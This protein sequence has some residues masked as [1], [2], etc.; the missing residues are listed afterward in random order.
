MFSRSGNIFARHFQS[1]IFLLQIC[2]RLLSLTI[3]VQR[4]EDILNILPQATKQHLS[5]FPLT[6][7]SGKQSVLLSGRLIHVRPKMTLVSHEW[8][9]LISIVIECTLLALV[10]CLFLV[11]RFCVVHQIDV[12]CV[13]QQ[14]D[15]DKQKQIRAWTGA[16]LL[17]LPCSRSVEMKPSA[18]SLYISLMLWCTQPFIISWSLNC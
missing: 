10:R 15:K 14:I 7:I 1:M 9:N 16:T 12:C 3:W 8:Q 2:I 17:C 18:L 6:F 4:G 5:S 13:C 11:P